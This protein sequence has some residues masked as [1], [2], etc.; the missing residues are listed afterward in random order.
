[1]SDGQADPFAVAVI[2]LGFLSL[3]QLDQHRSAFKAQAA[4]QP[5]LT[6]PKF[7]LVHGHLSREQLERVQSALRGGAVADDPGKAM[8]KLYHEMMEPLSKTSLKHGIYQRVRA[9]DQRL[10]AGKQLTL[11]WS[12]FTYA[13]NRAVKQK[14]LR[15]AAVRDLFGVAAKI[16]QEYPNALPLLDQPRCGKAALRACKEFTSWDELVAQPLDARQKLLKSCT[17]GEK[18]LKEFQEF[19]MEVRRDIVSTNRLRYAFEYY[20]EFN[21]RRALPAVIAALIL[22]AGVWIGFS[23][24]LGKAAPM[25]FGA[26]GSLK[27]KN[28]TVMT[29]AAKARLSSAQSAAPA[30]V[31]TF[32]LRGT[33]GGTSDLVITPEGFHWEHKRW[34]KP[35]GGAPIMVDS[36][37][38]TPVWSGNTSAPYVRQPPVLPS[39]DA[40]VALAFGRGSAELIEANDQKLVIRLSDSGF[41]ADSYLLNIS[42]VQP[43]PKPAAPATDK[44]ASPGQPVEPAAPATGKQATP[45]KPVEPA[46][47]A[48]GKQAAPAK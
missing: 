2:E 42:V 4:T 46:A 13:V 3:E 15:D 28:V 14:P 43:P 38:W 26:Q 6:F 30:A 19:L 44:Q 39:D 20:A 34:A 32:S 16:V 12:Q 31:V 27:L 7:L 37:P 35:G 33:F 18:L 23:S 24:Y 48:T 11:L 1:M 10:L 22:F 21:W 47:P 8:E 25:G 29:P 45:G 5:G 9:I 17:D 36:T 40:I 41:G